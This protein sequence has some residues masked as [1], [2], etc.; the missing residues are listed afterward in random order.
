MQCVVNGSPSPVGLVG[1]YI[2]LYNYSLIN[3]NLGGLGS[4]G[5]PGP[6]GPQ[7]PMGNTGH[8][9]FQNTGVSV[10]GYSTI[11]VSGSSFDSWNIGIVNPANTINIL[12]Q[13]ISTGQTF[14]I[15]VTNT[16]TYSDYSDGINPLLYWQIDG[17]IPVKWPNSVPAPGPN[18]Q[19]ASLY[20]FLRFPSTGSQPLIFSTFSVNYPN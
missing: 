20:T 13:G 1:G 4:S 17:S 9:I 15:K 11:N 10:T 18:P 2:Q 7:G 14:I 6:I 3:V 19:T 5:A 8:S 16:G 12:S